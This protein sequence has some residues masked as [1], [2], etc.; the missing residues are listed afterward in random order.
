MVHIERGE[1]RLREI[2]VELARSDLQRRRGLA[3]RP[4]MQPGWGMLFVHQ[5][6][7]V[8]TYTVEKM[9]FAIDIVFADADGVVVAVREGLEPGS[10]EPVRSGG[11]AKYALE[12]ASGS[13]EVLAGDRLVVD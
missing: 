4:C 2:P 8:L 12:V 10:P 7:E 3:E 6:E 13:V 5:D 1:T 11:A 9:R